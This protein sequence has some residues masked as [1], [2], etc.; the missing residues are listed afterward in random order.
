MA[1]PDV[2]YISWKLFFPVMPHVAQFL[3]FI[4]K[5]A[6]LGNQY[7][8]FPAESPIDDRSRWQYIVIGLK[9]LNGPRGE[10]D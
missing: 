2:S 7:S 8:H 3:L 6:A 10:P 1:Q 9:K 5:D 4:E